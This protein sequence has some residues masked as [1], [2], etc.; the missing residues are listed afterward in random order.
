MT[1]TTTAAKTPQASKTPSAS[2]KKK[3]VKAPR[4]ASLYA[5]FVSLATT[6]EAAK[7][8]NTQGLPRMQFISNLW[9]SSELNKDA[10]NFEADKAAAVMAQLKAEHSQK[11]AAFHAS[12]G[13]PG[14][15]GNTC[16][17]TELAQVVANGAQIP[18]FA[19]SDATTVKQSVSMVDLISPSN[20]EVRADVQGYSDSASIN[21]DYQESNATN[22][23]LGHEWEGE[24]VKFDEASQPE[25]EPEAELEAEPEP[26][27]ESETESEDESEAEPEA[28]PEAAKAMEDRIE[29][30]ETE[31][32]DRD[33][34]IEFLTEL[35]NSLQSDA[36]QK[37]NVM[38][39]SELAQNVLV[40]GMEA[41]S[42][43][44][45]ELLGVMKK[46]NDELRN[47]KQKK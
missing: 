36:N 12:H 16:H 32:E 31:L 45:Y 22:L 7:N 47:L 3:E 25:A 44:D 4:C 5:H 13:N 8:D 23:Q 18:S 21:E 41:V 14:N 42:Q 10:P 34:N 37:D 46:F 9:K 20:S 17:L 11:L 40:F 1:N 28:E 38:L 24:Y 27:T 2:K 6:Q 26:E 19:N 39:V 43:D 30:L 29:Q 35:N 33:S 15:T